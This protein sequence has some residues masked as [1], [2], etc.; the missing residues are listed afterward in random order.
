MLNLP[1]G[2]SVKLDIHSL[3]V[4]HSF[5]VPEFGQKQ[6]AVPGTVQHLVIT[7]TQDGHLSGHLHRALRPRPRDDANDDRRHGAGQVRGLGQARSQPASSRRRRPSRAQAVFNGN[8]CG[9]CHTLKAAGANG[10][11]GP[12]LD[13]LPAEAQRA[14]EP[15]EA[16]V[17]ESIVD[18]GAYV[19]PGFPK[20]VMPPDFAKQLSKAQVDALVQYLVQSS[21]GTE[22]L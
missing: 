4:I 11:V 13:K 17:R 10:K 8:G 9:A 14:G 15:V 22:N 1:R 18:P 12:D 20:G 3:D 19:E 6:D 16:F 7:P 2:E 21:K 5:W